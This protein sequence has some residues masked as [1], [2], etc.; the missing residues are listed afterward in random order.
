VSPKHLNK[1]VLVT[2]SLINYLR[3]NTDPVTNQ[4]NHTCSPST[5][6]VTDLQCI[7]GNATDDNPYCKDSFMDFFISP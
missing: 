3:D 4:A 1:S 7:S 2:S 6:A 5:Y